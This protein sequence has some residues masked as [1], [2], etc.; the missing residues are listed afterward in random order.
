MY[1]LAFFVPDEALEAVKQAVFM[2]G[3]GRIG[4][5]EC[6]CWQVKGIG[7]FRP[8][9]GSHPHIGR[10]NTLEQLPEWRV[11]LVCEDQLIAA[12]VAA[13]KQA[14]PYEEVA[15]DVWQLADF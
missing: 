13:L 5:Y 3:A 12:A 10:V 4:Q 6:C 1:K 9:P 14:H 2:S 11:E 7:Q 15:Y 8:L